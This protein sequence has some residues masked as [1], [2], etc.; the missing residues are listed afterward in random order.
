MSHQAGGLEASQLRTCVLCILSRQHAM[1][2]LVFFFFLN[3]F[4]QVW[5]VA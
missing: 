2:S 3:I 1:P 4:F 5:Y